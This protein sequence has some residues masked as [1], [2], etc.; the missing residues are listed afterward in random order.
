MPGYTE[1]CLWVQNDILSALKKALTEN[2]LNLEDKLLEKLDDI[3]CE[4]VPQ[5][6]REKIEKR[7]A[8][9]I[10]EEKKKRHA[11]RKSSIARAY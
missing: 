6:Q 10:F 9:Q 3:Y 1:V 4:Y 5:P 2:E 7:I 11:V 8:A